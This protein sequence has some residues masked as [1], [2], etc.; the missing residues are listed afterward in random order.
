[1]P[2]SPPPLTFKQVKEKLALINV[3]F[4]DPFQDGKHSYFAGP[5]TS[6]R[7]YD[8]P[9]PSGPRTFASARPD[10]EIVPLVTIYNWLHQLGV[11]GEPLEQFWAAEDHLGQN[12]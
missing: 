11:V 10:D 8:F 9:H 6:N 4:C 5:D 3:V 7:K 2:D 12:E 1:M